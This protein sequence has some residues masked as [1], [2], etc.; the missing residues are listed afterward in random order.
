MIGRTLGE[1]R[2]HIEALACERGAYVLVCARYGDRP[3]PA[4]GLRFDSR[5][6][7]RS[8]ARATEQYRAE[9][10]QYDP[11]LPHYDV[12]VCEASPRGGRESQSTDASRT[13]S[14]VAPGHVPSAEYSLVEYCHDAA[15]ALFESIAASDHDALED[16]IMD[17]YFR[18]AETVSSPDELCLCLLE[19]M[20]QE[21][22]ERLGSD[23]QARLLWRAASRLPPPT[24][25]GAD[26]LES[27][28]ERLQ[29]TALASGYTVHPSPAGA[30]GTP[31]WDVTV[32]EYALARAGETVIT[33]PISI[34]LF[35]H[36]ADPQLSISLRLSGEDAVS[37][38]C[39][40]RVSRLEHP[41]SS[42]LVQLSATG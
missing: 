16:A 20:A 9:L 36:V 33:L 31:T 11:Q 28:L 7:A 26:S 1:I 13:P 35:R 3:V 27:A 32:H 18:V 14:S 4:A 6:T 15:G 29:T 8:A 5:A 41:A 2:T 42:G 37:S 12:I 17:T 24:G 21:L 39:R 40:L 38:A 22:D 23:E 30:T 19:S 10:R 25:V 34:E